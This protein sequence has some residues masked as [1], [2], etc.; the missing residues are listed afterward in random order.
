M[1]NKAPTP[2][3]QTEEIN[4]K[5][6]N[7]KSI[8]LTSLLTPNTYFDF[9]FGND[10]FPAKISNVLPDGKYDISFFIQSN[11]EKHIS[12]KLS[13]R[14]AFFRE[15]IYCFNNISS[16]YE[17]PP[18]IAEIK[19]YIHDTYTNDKTSPYEIVQ[20]LN[21]YLLDVILNILPELD[22]YKEAFELVLTII[23]I[24][25]D[26]V[27]FAKDNIDKLKYLKHRQLILVD[28]D[29]AKLASLE[30]LINSLSTILLQNNFLDNIYSR[31]TKEEVE[32]LYM[33]YNV[34]KKMNEQRYANASTF[35]SNDN[36]QI[37]LS[38]IYFLTDYFCKGNENSIYN[39]LFSFLND[40]EKFSQI[41]LYLIQIISIQFKI[42]QHFKGDS[43]TEEQQNHIYQFTV[44]RLS[45]LSEI[46]LK[47]IRNPNFIN[48]VAKVISNFLYN[49][50]Q[51]NELT[52]DILI[53]EHKLV[54]YYSLR[55]LQSENLEK[56]I[57][58]I[59]TIN[60]IFNDIVKYPNEYGIA[61]YHFLIENKIIQILLGENVHDEILKRSIPLFHILSQY[62]NHQNNEICLPDFTYELLWDNYLNKHESV[63]SQ[64]ENI[65]CNISNVLP[66]D[67]KSLLYNKLKSLSE[68]IIANSPNKFFDFV[69]RLTQESI[70]LYT[71]KEEE[72]ILERK[73]K[74]YGIPLLYDYML[75]KN[76]ENSIQTVSMCVDCLADILSNVKNVSEK[77]VLKIIEI[78]LC[79]I[80]K[81]TSIVQSMSL[82]KS[83]I[84]TR[85]SKELKHQ[86]IKTLDNKYD[87]ISILVE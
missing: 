9:N 28:K 77:T 39:I 65:I 4:Q 70:S 27:S 82:I 47:E 45:S 78:L 75:D 14:I 2:L 79:N 76:G 43:L 23:D 73:D 21:G 48:D 63:S 8:P 16:Y 66:E 85:H 62:T 57:N 17:S 61:V 33:K 68:Q 38:L 3:I 64:I 44:E 53:P 11:K 87:I 81:K 71:P 12:I 84:K 35:T 5:L 72:N 10:W 7:A 52:I 19:Q 24:I 55:C 54:L 80:Q 49:K 31:F 46:E 37:Q 51:T 50:N 6:Q 18:E 60:E 83:I 58:A 40:K 1:V 29:Y 69:T 42:L 67:K 22:D 20:L 59:N 30:L 13:N 32:N 74:L 34:E 56:K 86:T 15:H 25:A 26:V 41:P 36:I